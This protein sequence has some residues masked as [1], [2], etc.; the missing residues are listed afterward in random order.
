MSVVLNQHAY[1]AVL[2]RS[3]DGRLSL[4]LSRHPL[5]CSLIALGTVVIEA[6]YPLA[7]FSGGPRWFFAPAMC[8]ALIGIRVLMGP[9]FPQFILCQPVLDPLGSGAGEGPAG[10]R[11][12]AP[13]VSPA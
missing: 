11:A 6:G 5:V 13:A 3:A 12:H 4:F 7:L 9:S 2:A 10:A 8:G 1:L